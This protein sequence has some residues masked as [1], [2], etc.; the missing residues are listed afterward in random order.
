MWQTTMVNTRNRMQNPSDG[1][2]EDES[3]ADQ[4]ALVVTTE[5]PPTTNCLGGGPEHIPRR[6]LEPANQIMEEVTMETRIRDSMMQAMNSSM[7]QQQEFFM[8]LLEDRDASHRQPETMAENIVNGS[9]SG[10]A[11]VVTEEKIVTRSKEKIKGCTYKAFMWCNPKEFSGSANPVTCMYWLKEVEMAFESSEC[12]DSQRVKFASQLLRGEA[13]IWWNLTRTALTPEV[14]GKL[15]WPV[16]KKKIMD[17]YCSERSLDKLQEEFKNLKKVALSITDYSKLFLEKLNLVGHLVPD[18][19]SKIKDYQHG[20]PV[21]MRTAVRNAKGSTLQEVVEESLL[22]EDDM[23][24]KKEERSQ[25]GEKRKWEG[26]FGPVRQSKLFASGR[27]GDN[28]RETRWC[29]KCKTKHFGPCNPRPHSGPAECAKCGNKGH[30]IRECPIWG[31]VCFECREPGHV[32]RDCQKLVGS[33]RGSSFGST[34]RVEQPSRAPSRA[35]WMTTEEA[36]E[37]IDVVSGTF[38]VNSLSARVLF[39]SGAT[40]SF[41]SNTF[42]K[43]KL[44]IDNRSIL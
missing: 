30:T 43:Q 24:A 4:P 32:K 19:R 10:L 42:C 8:K 9:G 5:G 11:V 2:V 15:T 16:F 44:K 14:L 29:H 41:V 25:V 37:T 40:C 22:V 27:F 31:P 28:R 38:L 36:K 20:L 13:L 1:H 23:V 21:E 18:E 26:P 33:N 7:A 35:F 3:T 39:D 34:T 12:D 6:N 17:K